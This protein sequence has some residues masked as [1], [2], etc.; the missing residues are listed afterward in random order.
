M[1]RNRETQNRS[2]NPPERAELRRQAEAQLQKQPANRDILRV[3]PEEARRLLHELEVHQIELEMQNEELRQAQE[4]LEESRAKYFKFYD[5]AP[6]GYLT[7]GETGIILEVNL[8]AAN[9]LGVEKSQLVKKP[10]TRFI[11]KE[12]QGIY[13]KHRQ[14]LYETR[15]R[16]VCELRM[17]G[18][19][20]VPFWVNLEA[21]AAQD[22]DGAPLCR[23]VMS[24]IT[25]RKRAEEALRQAEEN[26]RGIFENA[27]EGI[28]QSSPQG[29]FTSVNSALARILGYASPAQVVT[30]ITNIRDQFYADPG[31]RAIAIQRLA[32]KGTLENFESECLCKDGSRIWLSENTRAVRDA[33]GTL[34]HYEG[35]VQ[36]ITARKRAEESLHESE[37]RFATVFRAS[38]VAISLRI[39]ADGRCIDVNEAYLRLSGFSREEVI[40]YTTPEMWTSP[41]DRQQF[42][43]RLT[44]KQYIKNVESE[45]LTKSGETCHVLASYEKIQLSGNDCVLAM[46]QD[47]T[48]RKRT[49]EAV[50]QAHE[51]LRALSIYWQ[52]AIEAQRAHIAREI[53]DEFGQSMSALK[54]DLTWLA[55]RLPEG[56][57]R[58]DRIRTMTTLVDDSIALMRRIAT[59]LRPGLLDDLG[60][61]AALD[62][63]AR[64]FSRH[65][66]IP[67]N[68]KLPSDDLALAPALNT[69]LFR[70]FQ[71]TLTNVARHAQ[72][73]RVDASF[74]QEGKTLVLTVQDNGR[75]ITESEL[76][77]PHSLGLL[78]LRERATQW[79][80][81]L[82]IRNT[83]G[84]GTTV[85]V[86]I[87]L[88]APPM[89][90][91]N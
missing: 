7:I 47:I 26:Y 84:K 45:F 80:G 9:L 21:I 23:V 51:Q 3:V 32:E 77:D 63:Q 16:Q 82:T 39:L 37:A 69:T 42:V 22:M 40:N 25:E 81:N 27:V 55:N 28:Y 72:A 75:G 62:W 13:Y 73:T 17:I 31:R 30:R 33:T 24:D 67:C 34:L 71:E 50:A 76:N 60:L 61:N 87:P 12:D 58:V 36:D 90:G 8:T 86:Y 46:F 35:F 18:K 64:E 74:Q 29:H 68:L 44:Q 85:S 15:A 14:Q 11:V 41:A 20:G 56:D 5:L 4:E 49:E 88:P 1:A 57:E 70:I 59:E 38:P 79:G 65:S 54:M 89:N 10:V 43:D 78:G 2:A 66:E 91:G 53:H 52:N 6:V 83:P 48:E 19:R